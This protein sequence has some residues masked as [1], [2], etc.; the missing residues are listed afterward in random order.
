MHVWLS[1]RQ[2][3]G[4][5]VAC[6]VSWAE[7]CSTSAPTKPPTKSRARPRAIAAKGVARLAGG[8]I[9]G[10]VFGWLITIS[11]FAVTPDS[12]SLFLAWP[13]S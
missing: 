10:A 4:K 11:P 3:Q 13:V 9:A 7:L 2:W 5:P 8:E 1:I 6:R 12:R